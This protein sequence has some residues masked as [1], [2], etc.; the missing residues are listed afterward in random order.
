MLYSFFLYFTV[1]GTFALK[2]SM[3][4]CYSSR[5][6]SH[7]TFVL[8]RFNGVIIFWDNIGPLFQNQLESLTDK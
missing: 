1:F 5:Q 8:L 3:F 4:S 2:E 6:I 7:I